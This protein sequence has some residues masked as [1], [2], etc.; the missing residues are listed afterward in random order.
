MVSQEPDR[1]AA[2]NPCGAPFAHHPSRYVPAYVLDD[3]AAIRIEDVYPLHARLPK[4]LLSGELRAPPAV[5]KA[6]CD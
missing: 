6:A 4:V 3:V 2:V 5:R 1:G